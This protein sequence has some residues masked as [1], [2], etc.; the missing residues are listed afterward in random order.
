[1]GRPRELEVVDGVTGALL[2]LELVARL[3]VLTVVKVA[4][5]V[6]D[7]APERVGELQAWGD[8][9]KFPDSDGV[10]VLESLWDS[11]G[12]ERIFGKPGGNLSCFSS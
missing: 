5:V 2:V 12:D 10:R 8:V 4:L 11:Q 7:E 3:E 9:E 1:M 6:I